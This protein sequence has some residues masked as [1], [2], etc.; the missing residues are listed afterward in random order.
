MNRQTRYLKSLG[1]CTRDNRD[2]T[3][4]THAAPIF[5]GSNCATARGENRQA[6]RGRPDAVRRNPDKTPAYSLSADLQYVSKTA[7]VL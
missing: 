6:W 2:G 7:G 5:K 3:A 1:L 4:S